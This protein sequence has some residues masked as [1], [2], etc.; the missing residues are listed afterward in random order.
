VT[1]ELFEIKTARKHRDRG[2]GTS[3]LGL[4]CLLADRHGVTLVADVC[5]ADDFGLGLGDLMEWYGK[6]SFVGDDE[7]DCAPWLTRSPQNI[8][9]QR[10]GVESIIVR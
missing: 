5:P 9:M 1:I 3:A 4:L 2:Y 7:D 8:S 6:Q 10:A